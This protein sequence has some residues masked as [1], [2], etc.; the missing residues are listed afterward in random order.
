MKKVNRAILFAALASTALLSSCSKDDSK[1]NAAV[2]DG[3]CTSATVDAYN[4]V[5]YSTVYISKYSS[6]STVEK[7]QTSCDN[8]KNLIAGN[9]CK[10]EVA[11]Q[12]VTVNRSSHDS[13]CNPVA[14]AL[15]ALNNPT[16]AVQTNRACSSTLVDSYNDILLKSVRLTKQSTRSEIKAVQ[17]A[18]GIFRVLAGR[19]TCDLLVEGVKKP[20]DRTSQDVRCGWVDQALVDLDQKPVVAEP[21]PPEDLDLLATLEAKIEMRVLAE[22]ILG[23]SEALTSLFQDGKMYVIRNLDYDSGKPFCSF[24]AINKEIR[25]NDTLLFDSFSLDQ[26]SGL[27]K[28]DL[29]SADAKNDSVAINCY[30]GSG[31]KAHELSVHDLKKAFKGLLDIKVIKAKK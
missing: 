7:A 23:K 2:K 4:D 24:M 9:S 27:L 6:R 15:Q 30:A 25:N 5:I 11:G 3:L 18:C 21:I 31:K 22:D 13:R 10:L 1:N 28:I 29:I 16:T 17:S 12:E 8:Y 20:I 14:E 26:N 19:D